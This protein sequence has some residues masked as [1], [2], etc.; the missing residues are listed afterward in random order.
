MYVYLV[1][2]VFVYFSLKMDAAR[3]SET[4]VSYSNITL[5]YNPED[6]DLNPL[7]LLHALPMPTFI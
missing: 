5:S 7:C 2:S 6:L 1:P 3:S 4:L